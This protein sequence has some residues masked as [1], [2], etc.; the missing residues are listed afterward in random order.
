MEPSDS[1]KPV[2]A[3]EDVAKVWKPHSR[4]RA[5]RSS[6]GVE[7]EATLLEVIESTNSGNVHFVGMDSKHDEIKVSFFTL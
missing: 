2:S 3:V 7:Y 1:N 6:D 4:C 5:I